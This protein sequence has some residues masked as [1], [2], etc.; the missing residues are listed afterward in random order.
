M[1]VLS[2]IASFIY[3]KL[4]LLLLAFFYVLVWSL[5]GVILSDCLLL[6]HPPPFF[7]EGLAS[8]LR[9]ALYLLVYLI[10]P[11]CLPNLAED[12]K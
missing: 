1:A 8:S 6:V 7:P 10:V 12:F 5:A 3:S 2:H 9:E 4:T 11:A